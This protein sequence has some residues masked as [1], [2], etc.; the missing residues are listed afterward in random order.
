MKT[1]R[2]LGII[3]YLLNHD[4]VPASRLAERFQVSV[5]TIQ[6]DIVTISETGIPHLCGRR[7]KRRVFDPA[8]L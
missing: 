5:R 4:H 1:D 7:E 8:E 6:R 3:I 2:I